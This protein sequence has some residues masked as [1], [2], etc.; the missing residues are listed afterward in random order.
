[1]PPRP[2]KTRTW[3]QVNI[4]TISIDTGSDLRRAQPGAAAEERGAKDRRRPQG[5][6]RQ[7]VEQEEPQRDR[8]RPEDAGDHALLVHPRGIEA[9]RARRLGGNREVSG[10][11]PLLSG[12]GPNPRTCRVILLPARA[13]V[14][15]VRGSPGPATASAAPSSWPSARP[16]SRCVRAT[17]TSGAPSPPT[18][19]IR[20]C[21]PPWTMIGRSRHQLDAHPREPTDRVVA[22]RSRQAEAEQRVRLDDDAIRGERADGA[23]LEADEQPD[24]VREHDPGDRQ[25]Q[26]NRRLPPDE[27]PIEHTDEDHRRRTEGSGEDHPPDAARIEPI[28]QRDRH[29]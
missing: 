3:T 2:A 21:G 7:G 24:E 26:H 18:S 4:N 5:P 29:G 13:P 9:G 22:A 28:R 1:M 8:E 27:E 15:T 10:H 25:R 16:A 11:D 20:S 19:Q 17:S 14:S 23:A 12:T 6:A